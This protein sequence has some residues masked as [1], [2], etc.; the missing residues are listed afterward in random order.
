MIA[1]QYRSSPVPGSNKPPP[2]GRWPQAGGGLFSRIRIKKAGHGSKLNDWLL[3]HQ[4]PPPQPSPRGGSLTVAKTEPWI[5]DAAWTPAR[6][7]QRDP[8]GRGH[9]SFYILL[10]KDVSPDEAA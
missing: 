1:D 9:D 5:L 4:K 8:H 6:T 10:T 7:A 3:H 2:W